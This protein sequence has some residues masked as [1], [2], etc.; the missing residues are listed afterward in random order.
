M[1]KIKKCRFFTI[2]TSVADF[3]HLDA[4]PAFYAD[5]DPFVQ[6]HHYS[7]SYLELTTLYLAIPSLV[8]A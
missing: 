4:D 6:K 7:I 2:L 8:W 5:A 3:E 1:N